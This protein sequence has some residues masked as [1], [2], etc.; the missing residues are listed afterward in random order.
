M[1]CEEFNKK[2]HKVDTWGDFFDFLDDILDHVETDDMKK[3]YD[4]LKLTK[5]WTGIT[6]RDEYLMGF[7][8]V[9]MED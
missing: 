5:E 8:K 4:A 7:L 9:R 6:M 1:K 2:Y 3:L